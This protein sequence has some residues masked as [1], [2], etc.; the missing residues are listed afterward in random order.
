M[1]LSKASAS[2]AWRQLHV[3]NVTRRNFAAATAREKRALNS[4]QLDGGKS[5]VK[6]ASATEKISTVN[7]GNESNNA[8]T[9]TP[10]NVGGGGGGGGFVL[11]L[12]GILGVGVAAAYNN[13]M[14][15]SDLIG[16]SSPQQRDNNKEEKSSSLRTNVIKIEEEEETIETD[17]T[18]LPSKVTEVSKESTV[19]ASL[20]KPLMDAPEDCNKTEAYIVKSETLPTKEDLKTE[21]LVT[22]SE[23]STA[24]ATKSQTTT[25]VEPSTASTTKLQTTIV[26]EPSTPTS[27]PPPIDE[28]K[29]MAEI[30]ALKKQWNS[31][32]DKALAEAH[33]E[34][35]KLSSLDMMSEEIDTLTSSQLKVRLIQLAKDLEERTKWEAVR[36]QEFLSMKE[37]EIEDRYVLLI[38][39]LRLEAE[40][41]QEQKL[42]QERRVLTCEAEEALKEQQTR[43][44]A[45]LENSMQIQEKAHEDDKIAF[46][47]KTE[48]A[49]NAK[50]EELFGNSLSKIK[51]EFAAKMNQRTQQMEQLS[52]KLTDLES[53][54][55]TSQDF[56]V[57]SLQ[58]HRITAAAIALI[59]KLES[60]EPSAAAVYALK[61]AASDNAVVSAAVQALPEAVSKSGLMTVQELQAGFEEK[62]F[63]QCRRAA[64]IPE[65]QEGLEG[66]L[67]GS[68][69][70]MIRS[71]PGPDEAAPE[72]EKDNSEYV[73]SRARRHVKLGELDKAVVEL[74]KLKGQTAYT[75]KDWKVRAKDRVAVDKSLKVIRMECA[76]ANENLSKGA[77]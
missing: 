3:P 13:G 31:Q 71:S 20:E 66:Q 32:S 57:G 16:D 49:T 19:E 41:L 28:S 1:V 48:E 46:E 61:T 56:Q 60:G 77:A 70:S 39:K 52:K 42:A 8:A 47:K 29:V 36:L 27:L 65:G 10:N 53:S 59:E 63:P 4:K 37:R 7:N 9:V 69:F 75:A 34:L 68:I 15:P 40:H 67:L 54:L 2:V 18:V 14:I 17:G 26:V 25:A 51:E 23:P 22:L 12:L 74:D 21:T 64:S 76:L 73:L 35:A 24:A 30:E 72:S 11:P 44:E 55:K 58:A 38:K 33:T 45:F 5:S 50:Y 62:V 43:S 6:A